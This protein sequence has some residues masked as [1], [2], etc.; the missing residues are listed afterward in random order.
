[1][2]K[3][4]I[5]VFRDAY[6]YACEVEEVDTAIEMALKGV[7]YEG[8]ELNYVFFEAS[9]AVEIIAEFLYIPIRTLRD[10]WDWIWGCD[11][12]GYFNP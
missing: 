2:I 4:F 7:K 5:K 12:G 11:V 3:D 6:K 9:G 1:M 8:K 10:F